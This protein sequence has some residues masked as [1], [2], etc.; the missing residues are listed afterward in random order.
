MKIRALEDENLARCLSARRRMERRHK[1]MEGLCLFL[2]NL[3]EGPFPTSAIRRL[4]AKARL[5]PICA[6]AT[7]F[8]ETHARRQ[9]K[10]QA[11]KRTRALARG[12]RPAHAKPV[13]HA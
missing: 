6:S 7:P 13:H 3:E 2:S 4:A 8:G 1:T 9:G 11:K 12:A 10:S 5:R